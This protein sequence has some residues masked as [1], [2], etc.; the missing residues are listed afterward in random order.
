MAGGAEEPRP[1]SPV[2]VVL[3][4]LMG[5]GK[6]SVATLVARALGR[7]LRDSDPDLQAVHG[8][9]AAEQVARD[10]A[11][12]LHR[13]EAEHLLRSLAE[14]PPP[15]IA[16]AASTIDDPRCRTALADDP[17]VVWL[18]APLPVLAERMDSGSHR[19][20]FQPDRL[21][22]LADQYEQRA[23]WFRE[24]ADII[25][26]VTHSTPEKTAATVLAALER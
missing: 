18:D 4:G 22:M 24:V 11:G 8:L 26:D 16:A 17:F 1:V 2:P 25:V 10:G 20:Q 3:I 9:T 21:A 6:T 15:V 23:G 19:P 13:R 5:S 12:V 14:Q 7:E